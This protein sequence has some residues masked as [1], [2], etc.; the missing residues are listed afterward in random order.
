MITPMARKIGGGRIDKAPP[1][2]QW[3]L[4]SVTSP[5]RAERG[6]K[7]L[8]NILSWFRSYG[9]LPASIQG[10]SET[11]ELHIKNASRQL[12]KHLKSVE[13]RAYKLAKK[14]EQRHLTNEYF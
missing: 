5:N 6:L 3:R 11:V 8:D 10:V 9:K 4:F 13:N 7:R 12:D 2:E 14:Y 1:F